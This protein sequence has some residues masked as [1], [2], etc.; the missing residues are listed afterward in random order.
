[1]ERYRFLQGRLRHPALASFFCNANSE[2]TRLINSFATSA[3]RVM[4][5]VNRTDKV[6]HSTVLASVSRHDVIYTLL[7]RQLRFLGHILR[8]YRALYEHSMRTL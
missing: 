2:M 6:R 5:S 4:T 3:Y 1:M 8:S 7:S